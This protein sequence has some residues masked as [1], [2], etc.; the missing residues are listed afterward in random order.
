[1]PAQEEP[2]A[3]TRAPNDNSNI[4]NYNYHCSIVPGMN[5]DTDVGEGNVDKDPPKG[6]EYDQI[7]KGEAT[8]IT[9]VID[10]TDVEEKDNTVIVATESDTHVKIAGYNCGYY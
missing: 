5:N 3:P 8:T 2:W 9:E 6:S 10:G 7:N 4:E 1:M